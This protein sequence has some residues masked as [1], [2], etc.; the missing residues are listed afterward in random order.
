LVIILRVRS[1]SCRFSLANFNIC[2]EQLVVT[3]EIEEVFYAEAS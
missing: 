2:P 1:P 3:S